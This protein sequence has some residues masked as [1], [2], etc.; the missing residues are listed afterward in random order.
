MRRDSFYRNLGKKKKTNK[1]EKKSEILKSQDLAELV[2]IF[3]TPNDPDSWSL[4][5]GSKR[6]HQS[7]IEEIHALTD[8]RIANKCTRPPS[9][10]VHIPLE[11][12][13]P[14]YG[15]V[16]EDIGGV[17][18]NCVL[19]LLVLICKKKLLWS[20]CGPQ[21]PYLRLATGTRPLSSPWVSS[22]GA[23]L[24]EIWPKILE[25]RQTACFAGSIWG[26][27]PVLVASVALGSQA[28][29]QTG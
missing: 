18:N 8:K 12:R 1:E 13:I 3:H 7:K 17:N 15:H 25:I 2:C 16:H 5:C 19:L 29:G 6:G 21:K 28:S 14:G 24:S 4:T 9:Y 11:V 10:G 20:A 27:V 23:V 26:P 22:R